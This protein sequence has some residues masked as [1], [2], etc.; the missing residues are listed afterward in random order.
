M[1]WFVMACALAST[2]CAQDAVNPVQAANINPTSP[3]Q[4]EARK[5]GTSTRDRLPAEPSA[6]VPKQKR[7]LVTMAAEWMVDP[8]EKKAQIVVELVPIKGW[9]IYWLNPGDAGLATQFDLEQ[10]GRPI[11]QTT[12]MPTPKRK[13]SSGDIVSFAFDQSTRFFLEPKDFQAAQPIVVTARWLACAETCIKGE[14]RVELVAFDHRPNRY[15][16]SIPQYGRDWEALP[17]KRTMKWNKNQKTLVYVGD[18]GTTVSLFPH[19][20]L[21]RRL[22]GYDQPYCTNNRCQLPAAILQNRESETRLWATMQVKD[23]TST[24]AYQ[25]DIAEGYVP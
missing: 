11:E 7:V 13:V 19:V 18:V 14:E 8:T 9:Y 25:T 22:D 15:S 23:A 6:N 5:N 1:R 12:R 2:A 16:E 4:P 20:E 24:K 21:F 17:V 10:S 3:A